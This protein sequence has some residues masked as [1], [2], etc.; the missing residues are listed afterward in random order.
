M[1]GSSTDYVRSLT[2][3]QEDEQSKELQHYIAGYISPHAP[4][5]SGIIKKRYTDF[6]VN[7]ILPNGEVAHLGELKD[8]SRPKPPARLPQPA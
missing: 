7:E 3:M 2:G 1:A 5:F 8:P 6:L 4:R